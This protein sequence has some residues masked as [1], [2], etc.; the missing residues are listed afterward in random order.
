M[1]GV[2][3]TRDWSSVEFLSKLY[4]RHS[5]GRL[6]VHQDYRKLLT[7]KVYYSGNNQAIHQ[8]PAIYSAAKYQSVRGASRFLEKYF[9]AAV[10]SHGSTLQQSLELAL[11]HIPECNILGMP[12]IRDDEFVHALYGMTFDTVALDIIGQQ[13]SGRSDVVGHG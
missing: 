11:L 1:K 5:G 7:K 9:E 6:V 2:F 10:L 3:C 12:S 8:D 13:I 4:S